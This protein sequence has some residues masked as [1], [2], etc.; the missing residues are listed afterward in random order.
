MS[1][2]DRERALD[3][4]RE[5]QPEEEREAAEA[6]TDD[7]LSRARVRTGGACPARRA[8]DR[9]PPSRRSSRVADPHGRDDARELHEREDGGGPQV[10]QADRLV[11]DLGLDRRVPRAAEDED[12]AERRER[13]EEDDRGGGR[14]RGR[15]QRHA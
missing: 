6:G 10:E 2:S 8:A 4:D 11:V 5:R 7:E 15:E 1:A 14:E 12:D 9:V 3:E 13:E